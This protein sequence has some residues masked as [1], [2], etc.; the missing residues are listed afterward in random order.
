MF[1]S[2]FKKQDRGLLTGPV[3]VAV[4]VNSNILTTIWPSHENYSFC[5]VAVRALLQEMFNLGSET[6]VPPAFQEQ[7]GWGLGM[8]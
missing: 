5:Q 3:S 2:F 6:S 4:G 7:A 1:F 8:S